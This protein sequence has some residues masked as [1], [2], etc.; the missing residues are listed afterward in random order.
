VGTLCCKGRLIWGPGVPGHSYVDASIRDILPP[1]QRFAW[2]SI[3]V[4]SSTHL[5]E[6]YFPNL[7]RIR[8]RDWLTHKDIWSFLMGINLYSLPKWIDELSGVGDRNPGSS[9]Y[10]KPTVK[11]PQGN[12]YSPP[13]SVR[14]REGKFWRDRMQSHKEGKIPTYMGKY[15][16]ISF[17]F[18]ETDPPIMQ[19]C[20]SSIQYFPKFE[21]NFP[22]FTVLHPLC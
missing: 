12:L 4:S 1:H 10:L 15:W 2:L 6:I 7:D 22:F 8:S 21:E 14:K 17:Y 20:T 11:S 3:I 13:I 18:G 5:I 19:L 9:H 16:R